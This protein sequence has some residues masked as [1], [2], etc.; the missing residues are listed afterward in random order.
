[1][2]LGFASGLR[3]NRLD[4]IT[5]FAG[6]G[7]ICRIY[8]G[9]RPATGA[10]ISTQT[11]LAVLTFN[12]VAFAAAAAAGVLTLNSVTPTTNAAATGQAVWFR[13]V[14]A[15]GSTFVMDGDVT[16]QSGNG[17]MKLD[18]VNIVITGTVAMASGV[19]NEGNA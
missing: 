3:N 16:S 7:A 5:A 19:I 9:T 6:A 11:L 1:M 12:A 2:S 18:N 10:G 4:Q 14:K 17:D 8:S 13:V 15:D